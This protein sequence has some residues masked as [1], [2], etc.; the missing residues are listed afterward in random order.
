M[1][2]KIFQVMTKFPGNSGCAIAFSELLWATQS[3]D[4]QT[5]LLGWLAEL[6]F[7]MAVDD[8]MMTRQS[9]L[10]DRGTLWVVN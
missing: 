2:D 4:K 8:F 1:T 7:G 6:F 9:H 5:K 10:A 3:V